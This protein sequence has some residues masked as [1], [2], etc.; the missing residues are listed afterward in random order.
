MSLIFQTKTSKDGQ[1][2]FNLLSQGKVLLKSEMYAQ[3]RSCDNGIESVKKNA[4]ETKHYERAV[5]QSGKHYF[6]LKASNGQV[7]GTSMM[8]DDEA[9][10]EAAI[11]QCQQ[12]SN[13]AVEEA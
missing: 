12:A 2:Y 1:F 6:N 4:S 8:H 11:L 7:I 10:L 5:A 13:A 9:S 3:K